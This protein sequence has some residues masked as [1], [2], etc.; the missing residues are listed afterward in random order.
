VLVNHDARRAKGVLGDSTKEALDHL[1]GQ[2]Q[3]DGAWLWLD[4]GLRP[5][6]TEAPYFGASLAALAVG[7]AGKDFYEDKVVQPKVESLKKYLVKQMPNQRLH[8]RMVLLWTSSR[9]PGVLSEPGRT[10]LVDEILSVQQADGGW[11]SPSL[12]KYA[13]K[14]GEWKSHGATQLDVV[15]DGYATG[16]A[17][18][19]LKSVRLPSDDAKLRRGIAWLVAHQQ[20]DGTWPATYLN[21]SRDPE[22]DVGKFMRDAATAFAVMALSESS[23]G[24]P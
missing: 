9:L 1:W 11:S 6:E 13:A 23:I 24:Q 14:K 19:A 3:T 21:Q 20:K 15:S 5:W 10:K 22:S 17:V 2:Q 7:M 12:G 16:L 8:H 4:F 18:L